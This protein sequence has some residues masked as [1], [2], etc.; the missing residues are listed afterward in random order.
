MGRCPAMRP[1]K[2]LLKDVNKH[3]ITKTL[4]EDA[5]RRRSCR[6]Y[7]DGARFEDALKGAPRWRFRK[8]LCESFS[9]RSAKDATRRRCVKVLHGGAPRK[10]T[11]KALE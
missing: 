3:N 5:L 2:E 10:R 4:K 7:L 1:E 9:R 8:A 11:E 6:M